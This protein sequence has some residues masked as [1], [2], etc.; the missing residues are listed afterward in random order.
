[1]KTRPKQLGSALAAGLLLLMPA[2]A[3]ADVVT[4]WNAIMQTTVSSHNAFFQTRSAAI[5]QLAVF[6]AVNGIIGDYEPYLGT[7]HAPAGA[8]PEAAAVAAAHRVLTVLYPNPAT[9]ATLDQQRDA[10]LLALPDG[11]AKVAGIEFGLLAAN[12]M[13]ALRA[14]D[15]SAVVVPYVPGTAAGQW[16]PT[17]PGYS[18]ALLPGWGRVATFGIPHGGHLRAKAPPALHTGKYARDLQEVR[19]V[20]ALH[21]TERPASRTDVARTY[22]ALLVVNLYNPIARQLSEQSGR[23]LSENARIFALLGIAS[24][25]ALI[26]SMESKYHYNV[27]R[28]ATAIVSALNAQVPAH[29]GWQPLI[30]EPPFP[31]YPSNHACAAGAA[32][33]VLEELFGKDDLAITVVS[34]NVPGLVLDYSTMEAI[35]SDIDDARIFGGIHFRFD[36]EEGSR[37]GRQIGRYVLRHELRPLKPGRGG[38]S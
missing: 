1:M 33:A 6:E 16:R 24:A 34:P 22:A 17:A 32:R 25:D 26:S 18:P 23:T 31:S 15:G 20:G 38:S 4:D 36:Q 19:T 27:W 9:V 2:T 13:L 7:L 11:P 37:Q 8:S 29:P 14:E 21:S 10:S 28:P 12:E 5:T 35:A 3:S 30:T